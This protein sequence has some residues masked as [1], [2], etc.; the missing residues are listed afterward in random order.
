MGILL[1]APYLPN[2]VQVVLV[3][4][5]SVLVAY[6]DSKL[7]GVMLNKRKWACIL[8]TIGLGL[9]SLFFSTQSSDEP[10]TNVI[11]WSLMFSANVFAGAFATL[12]TEVVLKL[13][14]D[15]SPDFNTL[16]EVAMLNMCSN[17]Y[18]MFF[19]ILGVPLA[20]YS[21]SSPPLG[22]TGNEGAF[23]LIRFAIFT[24]P[25]ILYFVLMLVSSFIY[26]T[27]SGAIVVHESS[28][29]N[30]MC[31]SFGTLMQLLFFLIPFVAKAFDQTFDPP[32]FVLAVCITIVAAM[33][34]ATSDKTDMGKLE[35]SIIGQFFDQAIKQRRLSPKVP[36]VGLSVYVLSWMAIAVMVYRVGGS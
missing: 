18:G 35:A 6:V 12:C 22:S 4:F 1:S 33:Y 21:L 26:T 30:A 28:M 13:K 15:E 34:T 20:L 24:D 25:N 19:C 7:L 36:L 31:S 9:S 29:F 23:E 27:A 10:V 17:L 11:F 32:S 14:K 8:A 16:K 2:V 3:Q 5:Q